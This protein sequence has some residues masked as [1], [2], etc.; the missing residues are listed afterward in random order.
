MLALLVL[1]AAAP[2]EVPPERDIA[3]FT[4]PVAVAA[5]AAVPFVVRT[6]TFGV[7]NPVIFVPLGAT[8]T[9]ADYDWCIDAALVHQSHNGPELGYTGFWFGLGPVIHPGTQPLQ[10]L[11]FSPKLSVGAFR[12]SNFDPMGP[13]SGETMFN[14]TLGADFGYQFTYGRAYF[15]FVLG[16]SGGVGW[17]ETDG[18]AGPWLSLGRP[19]TSVGGSPVAGVN[20][21]LLR[22]GFTL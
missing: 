8:F 17:G 2:E 3:I 22:F 19:N 15:A 10:G 20:L 9:A 6:L 1:L 5:A 7:T 18:F 16:V 4:A 11:F 14:F 21:Q 12:I 13:A